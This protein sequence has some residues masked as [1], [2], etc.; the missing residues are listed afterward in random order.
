MECVT[1]ISSFHMCVN[2]SDYY[3]SRYSLCTGHALLS[4]FPDVFSVTG[5]L[6]ILV[7]SNYL[8][9]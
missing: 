8:T 1:T 2:L 4:G 9:V 5:G 3:L 6:S 7:G